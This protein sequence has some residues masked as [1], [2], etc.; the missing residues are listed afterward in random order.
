[1]RRYGQSAT[2]DRAEVSAFCGLLIGINLGLGSLRHVLT[3]LRLLL[4]T[5]LSNQ[6]LLAERGRDAKLTD[7]LSE[8]TKDCPQK[9]V[10]GVVRACDA[11]MP[12]LTGG[13]NSQAAQ[14]QIGSKLGTFVHRTARPSR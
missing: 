12:D 6:S 2:R 3:A 8:Q 1:V 4:V 14:M 13:G 9:N 10:R 7:W 5:R 11:I